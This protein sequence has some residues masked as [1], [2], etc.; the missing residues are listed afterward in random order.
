LTTVEV[1]FLLAFVQCS[2]A[3]VFMNF[4]EDDGHYKRNC[5]GNDK[6]AD[7]DAVNM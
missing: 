6:I 4:T 1:V 7:K 2:P 3:N 5:T